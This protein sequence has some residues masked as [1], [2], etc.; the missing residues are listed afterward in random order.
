MSTPSFSPKFVRA[1]VSLRLGDE[2]VPVGEHLINHEGLPGFPW[3][4][5]DPMQMVGTKTGVQVQG[6][7]DPA[8]EFNCEAYF[9][10]ERT[11]RG[12]NLG[13]VFLLGDREKAMLTDAIEREGTLPEYARKF[14][15]IP[16][17]EQITIMPSHGI[18]RFFY[19]G[20]D[21]AVACDVDDFSPSGFQLS[22]EDPRSATLEPG[23][24]VRVQIQPRGDYRHA[25]SANTSVQRVMYKMNAVTGNRRWHFG[26]SVTTMAAEHKSHFTE[27]LKLIVMKLKSF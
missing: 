5:F 27:L 14:P 17:N 26:L 13:L 3:D 16:Y 20:E 4:K 10:C 11:Q 1:K 21:M 23:A 12:S 22:T 9:T 8:F 6:L 25:F 19:H 2:F 18:I 24:V 7:T 15:R